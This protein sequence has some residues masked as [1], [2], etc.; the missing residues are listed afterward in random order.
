MAGQYGGSLLQ[1]WEQVN[2]SDLPP[3]DFPPIKLDLGTMFNYEPRL[4]GSGGYDENQSLATCKTGTSNA[5][6]LLPH[7]PLDTVETPRD[8]GTEVTELTG[9]EATPSVPA[10]PNGPSDQRVGDAPPNG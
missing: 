6:A 7:V 9:S 5:T 8:D 3:D 2:P 1:D 10:T 4:I